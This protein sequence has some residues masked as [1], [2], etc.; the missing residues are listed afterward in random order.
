MVFAIAGCATE[1][2]RET[3]VVAIRPAATDAS[4]HLRDGFEGETLQSFWLPGD[5]GSGRYAPGAIVMSTDHARSGRQSARITVSEGD[6]EQLG[7][8]GQR[9]ERAELDS[10]E[11][12]IID[13]DVWYGFSF[14]VPDGFPIVNTRLVIAQWKQSDLAGSP[15]VAQRFVAGRHYVTIRDLHTQGSWQAVFDL[16]RMAHGEWNDMVYHLRMSTESSGIVEIWMNG[17][18]VARFDGATVSPLG[19]E[20]FYHKV[21]LYRDRMTEPM[22]I[23]FDNYAI[24]ESFE[25]VN[26]A[27]FEDRR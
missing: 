3:V 23:Y 21:G 8:S 25:E 24:G 12:S 13:R 18:H 14:L 11:Q 27:T 7:D 20:Q 9:N 2:P 1:S 19:T 4:E 16:P 26:P 5:H 15:L 6:V 17:E 22:T 10:G